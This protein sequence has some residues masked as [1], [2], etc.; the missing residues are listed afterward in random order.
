MWVI[1][2]D[3]WSFWHFECSTIR[4]MNEMDWTNAIDNKDA[5]AFYVPFFF[6]TIRMG[7]KLVATMRAQGTFIWSIWFEQHMSTPTKE[8]KVNQQ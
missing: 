7:S 3:A 6:V 2:E 1:V 8:Y 5:S 4:Q